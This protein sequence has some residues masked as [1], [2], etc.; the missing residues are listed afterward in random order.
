[1]S[2][3]TF[4]QAIRAAPDDD[5]PRL[6]YADWLEE[7]GDPRGEF[8]RL[9]CQDALNPTLGVATRIAELEAEFGLEWAGPLEERFSRY[10]FRRGFVEPF[11]D[12]TTYLSIADALERTTKYVSVHIQPTSS[13]HRETL[14]ALAKSPAATHVRSLLLGHEWPLNAGVAALCESPYFQQLVLLDL[15]SGGLT[16]AGCIALAE[17][18]KLPA[19]R[20]LDLVNN[21]IAS[22]GAGALATSVH[23]RGLQR[24]NLSHNPIGEAGVEALIRSP[25]LNDLSQLLVIGI[26]IDGRTRLGRAL[27]RRFGDVVVWR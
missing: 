27:R 21:E 6:V 9:Q 1:M 11:I 17:T 14:E 10:R 19:L 18:W 7:R 12:P 24:L 3:A 22:T 13:V 16:D 20:H 15:H 25:C 4:L 26:G 2:E 5:L 23:R 8:I